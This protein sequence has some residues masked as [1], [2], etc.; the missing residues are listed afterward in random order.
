ML[1][2][3]ISAAAAVRGKVPLAAQVLRAAHLLWAAAAAVGEAE[4]AQPRSTTQAA[5]AVSPVQHL[6]M[7]VLVEVR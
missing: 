2:N 3:Q 7:R 4:K 1:R 6:L 5:L